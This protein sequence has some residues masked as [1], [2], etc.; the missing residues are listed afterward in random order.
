[1]KYVVTSGDS[2][3]NDP[4]RDFKDKFT[5]TWSTELRNYINDNKIG[6]VYNFGTSGAG[7]D[8]P[9]RSILYKVNELLK[10]G[11]ASSD[12]KVIV[13]WPHREVWDVPLKLSDRE[14][15]K[16]EKNLH[17]LKDCGEAYSIKSYRGGGNQEIESIF[18]KE[19]MYDYVLSYDGKNWYARLHTN[20]KLEWLL[21]NGTADNIVEELIITRYEYI[22][23]LQFFLQSN[24]IDYVFFSTLNSKRGPQNDDPDVFDEFVWNKSSKFSTS[25]YCRCELCVKI[26]NDKK[27][28]GQYEYVTGPNYRNKQL[29]SDLYPHIKIYFDQIDWSRWWSY[30][31]KRTDFGG[32]LEYITENCPFYYYHLK[33]S[34]KRAGAHHPNRHSW[35]KF[36]YDCL[37]PFIKEKKLI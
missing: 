11:V 6:K 18:N 29:M 22:V 17:L 3:S 21:K 5:G 15:K 16:I 37:L 14:I 26:E 7:V 25:F 20:E 31:S 34:D 2:F 30:T 10:D 36:F 27:W 1:M 4:C 13:N 24:N 23:N 12:I 9:Y 28:K 19:K 8:W 35:D 32:C 33:G